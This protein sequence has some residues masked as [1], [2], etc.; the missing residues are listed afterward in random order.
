MIERGSIVLE[1]AREDDRPVLV[2]LSGEIDVRYRSVLEETLRDCLASGRRTLVD[3]SEVTFMDSRCAQELAV[4][5]RL[6]R[7]HLFLCDPSPDVKVGVAACELEDWLE[8]VYT[9]RPGSAPVYAAS[10]VAHNAT[11]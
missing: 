5:Q 6:G 8:F 1:S 4:Y 7:G 10:S 11:I 9:A 3:L 2:R